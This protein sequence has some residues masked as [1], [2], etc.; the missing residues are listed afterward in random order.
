MIE[1]LTMQQVFDRV[2]THLLT[3]RAQ[4]KGAYMDEED[5]YVEDACAYRGE[6]DLKCAVGCLIRDE[7]YDEKLEGLAV[8]AAN[9]DNREFDNKK[10][11]S[12]LLFHALT[13]AGINPDNETM[14]GM[15][16]ELQQVHD[17]AAPSEWPRC[18]LK[19]ADDFKLDVEVIDKVVV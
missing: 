5:Y 4:S 2:A 12:M 15:L 18:L 19:M 11:R 17:S 9:K 13:N 7:D 3:Q 14:M 6:N 16:S 1:F 10:G 8:T